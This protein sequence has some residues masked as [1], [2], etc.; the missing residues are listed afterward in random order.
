MENKPNK[1]LEKTKQEVGKARLPRIAKELSEEVRKINRAK[2][3]IKTAKTPREREKLK[4]YMDIVQEKITLVLEALTKD[5]IDSATG[6]QM[7]KIL[8]TLSAELTSGRGGN[9]EKIGEKKINININVEKMTSE[10]LIEF[11]SK[12]SQEKD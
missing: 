5:K 7:A 11:L 8:R 4:K 3:K 9:V 2:K 6:A 12:K 10:E 1:Y